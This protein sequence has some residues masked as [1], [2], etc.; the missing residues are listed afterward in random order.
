MRNKPLTVFAL[1][2]AS[3]AAVL[4]PKTFVIPSQSH[5]GDTVAEYTSTWNNLDGPKLNFVNAT[6]FDWWYFDAVASDLS[7]QVSLLAYTTDSTALGYPFSLPTITWSMVTVL[8]PNGTVI[9]QPL[10]GEE[11]VVKVTGEGSSGYWNGTGVSWTS[12][13]DASFY[14]VEID[15]P[16]AGVQGSIQLVSTAPPRYVCD[17]AGSGFNERIFPHLGWANAVPDAIATVNLRIAGEHVQ[18][19]GHGYHDKNW[20]DRPLPQVARSWYWGH[21]RLGPY[22]LVWFHA[23]SFEGEKSVS[24][25]LVEN[26]RV[27][28]LS[29][30]GLLVRPAGQNSTYPPTPG[31]GLPDGF[32]IEVQAHDGRTF[33]ADLTNRDIAWEPPLPDGAYTR[34]T[35]AITGGFEGEEQFKGPSVHEWIRYG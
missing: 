20:G 9:E 18:F 21:A 16:S 1:P 7:A 3:A 34:W 23:L 35:G 10:L 32:H 30:S 19:L 24:G 5:A 28:A 33:I 17:R 26:G 14:R 6:S 12:T 25:Y 2:W 22:S 8:L 27:K 13:P 4:L 31:Q 29:C 15:N 11:A